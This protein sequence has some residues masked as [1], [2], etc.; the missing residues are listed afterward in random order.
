[1]LTESVFKIGDV[2][3]DTLTNEVGLLVERYDIFSDYVSHETDF[4]LPSHIWAWEILWSGGKTALTKI[5][6]KNSYTE[7]GL[8]QLVRRGDFKL[9][10]VDDNEDH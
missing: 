6:R 1:M 10:K 9:V 4:E 7:Q 8:I 3:I 2:V 5:K